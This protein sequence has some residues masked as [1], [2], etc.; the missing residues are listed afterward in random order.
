MITL[1]DVQ[2]RTGLPMIIKILFG[3]NLVMFACE[4]IFPSLVG[5]FC[6]QPYRCWKYP[7]KNAGSFIVS[8]YLHSN[9]VTSGA[10]AFLHIIFNM[11]TVNFI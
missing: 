9:P 6:F 5:I 10:F 11:M 3:V 7:L 8:N 2:N 1:S 4:L